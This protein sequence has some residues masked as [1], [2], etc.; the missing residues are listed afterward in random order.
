MET[1]IEIVPQNAIA[2]TSNVASESTGFFSS[3]WFRYGLLVLILAF[4]GFN[5]FTYLGKATDATTHAVKPLVKPA[6]DVAETAGEAVVDTAEKVL[7]VAAEGVEKAVH[8]AGDVTKQVVSKGA[9]G[10]EQVAKKT[11]ELT[12]SGIN[13]LQDMTNRKALD[14]ATKRWEQSQPVA[15]DAL[16]STQVRQSASQS[17]YCYIGEQGGVRSCIKV[18]E[19]DHCMSGDIFPTAAICINPSLRE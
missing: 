4:L 7:D 9:L 11:A 13:Q 18:N 19:H 3:K 10:V 17:G 2:A 6:L 8:V 1:S 15:D 14:D 5:V 12:T 16:S